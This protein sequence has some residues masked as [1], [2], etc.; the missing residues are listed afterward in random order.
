[1][2]FERCITHRYPEMAVRCLRVPA[3]VGLGGDGHDGIT[4][5][6][7]IPPGKQAAHCSDLRHHCPDGSVG[8]EGALTGRFV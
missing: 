4:L 1:M 2:I 7:R 8:L 3:A 6:H 5:V